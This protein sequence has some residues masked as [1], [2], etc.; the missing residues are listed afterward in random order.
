MSVE[1]PARPTASVPLVVVAKRPYG[2]W[3][4][5]AIVVAVVISIVT[6]FVTT[7]NISWEIVG[8]YLFN[9][10]ILSGVRTT[11]LLAVASMA[12]GIILGV[13]VGLMRMSG[14]RTLSTIAL[15]YT[16]LLRGIPAL[17]LLLIWGNIA[18]LVKSIEL[19]IP[20]TDAIFVTLNTND[21]IT[22]FTAAVIAFGLSEAAYLG[23]IVRAGLLSV[24]RGQVEAASALGMPPARRMRRIIMPQA[25]R[26]IIPPVGNQF[27]TMIKGT[28]LV[29][30]VAGGDVL[31]QA[32]NI[33]ASSYRIMEMLMVASF[34]FLILVGIASLG[35]MF[36]ERA[37]SKG[38][39]R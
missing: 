17:L 10:M 36:L 15:A 3:A 23:E 21:I 18:I 34:W 7:P 32:Q 39:D 22:P 2:V 29:S 27:V 14:N 13:A 28:S 12:V 9:P 8:E 37:V 11:I 1:A 26:V 6:T 20:F 5:T 31:T 16:T 4:F 24:D 25:M 33:A 30:V 35:Q 19:G 38:L